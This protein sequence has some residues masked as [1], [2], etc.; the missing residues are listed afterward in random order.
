MCILQKYTKMKRVGF[1]VIGLTVSVEWG[2]LDNNKY[3]EISFCSRYLSV[4]L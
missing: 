3:D 1:S 4:V 2:L